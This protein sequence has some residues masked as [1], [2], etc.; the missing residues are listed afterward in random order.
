MKHVN[1]KNQDLRWE[2]NPSPRKR[3]EVVRSFVE[4]Y[5]W[6][7]GV[8]LG[9][10]KGATFFYLLNKCPKLTLT[11]IDIWASQ[12]DNPD[13]VKQYIKPGKLW[14]HDQHEA[15]VRSKLKAGNYGDRAKLI[16]GL[17]YE[18][19]DQFKDNSIDFVFIDADHSENGVRRDIEA[20]YPKVKNTGYLC[21]HDINWVTVY[22]VVEELL[23]GY[24]EDDGNMWIRK[25]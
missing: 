23:P 3:W 5:N 20:W 1:T 11:G 19:A 15:E 14:D 25:K 8:E 18:V 17:S 22:N 9:V 12:P 24:S 2:G 6:K 21:G 10:W 13:Y 4:Q 16:R 7:I